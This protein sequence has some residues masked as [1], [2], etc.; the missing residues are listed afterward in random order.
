MSRES[1]LLMAQARSL[2]YTLLVTDN[3]IIKFRMRFQPL[4]PCHI[5]CMYSAVGRTMP[6]YF[7][8]GILG[9]LL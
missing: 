8:A 6:I 4:S 2:T 3:W 7:Q 5:H 1:I 9:R